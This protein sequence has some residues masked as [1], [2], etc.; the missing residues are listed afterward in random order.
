LMG[1]RK[2]YPQLPSIVVGDALY[3]NGPFIQDLKHNRC[4]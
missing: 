3:A 4:S 1:F 2:S